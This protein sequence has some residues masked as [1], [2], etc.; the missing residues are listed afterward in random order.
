METN[1]SQ[2]TKLI[3]LADV[4]ERIGMKKSY[5]FTAIKAGTFPRP[6]KQGRAALF[7]STEIDA[8][9][10][11]RI[12]DRDGGDKPRLL[13][14]EKELAAALKV[15]VSYLQ[16]DRLSK[17]PRIPFVKLGD[18]VRYDVEKARG[19]LGKMQQGGVP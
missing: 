7:V 14:T 18:A 3:R 16:K 13:A 12:A 17:A 4:L 8:W 10:H 11:A 15:S 2:Q 19:A 6:V 9:I 5:V 1:G